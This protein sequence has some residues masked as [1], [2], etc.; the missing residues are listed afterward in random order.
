MCSGPFCQDCQ[1]CY[2]DDLNI[3]D[4]SC[5][6][7]KSFQDIYKD[8]CNNTLTFESFVKNDRIYYIIISVI[9]FMI[10]KILFLHR[11]EYQQPYQP[12]WELN[13]RWYS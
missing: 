5:C 2:I 13:T 9:F 11:R 7:I 10:I 12:S 8:I 6:L 4:I 1:F 3:S